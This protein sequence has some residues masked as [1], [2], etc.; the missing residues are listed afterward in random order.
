MA[1]SKIQSESLNLADTFAFTGTVTGTGVN[2]P[3]VLV[4][5]TT[6]TTFATNAYVKTTLD[7]EFI[8]TDNLFSNSRFTVTSGYEGKYLVNWRISFNFSST[9]QFAQSPI[10]KNGSIHA[11]GQHYSGRSVNHT[12]M[13]EV[14]YVIDMT[15]ND[16]LEFYGRQSDSS[17]NN[18]TGNLTHAW[19][20]K[21]IT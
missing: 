19:I 15:T 4:R 9:T 16:Y 11:Y 13:S 20:T 3:T 10:Y 21:L 1:I 14:T 7:N 12:M 8:D 18:N 5:A 6:A 17:R 2:T